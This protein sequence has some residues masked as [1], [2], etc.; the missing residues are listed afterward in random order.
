MT[1]R[2]TT[3]VTEVLAGGDRR[4]RLMHAAE[5]AKGRSATLKES[6]KFMEEQKLRCGPKGES[7]GDA[8]G[9]GKNDD[10]KAE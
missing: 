5:K 3:T 1:R 2:P 4:S 8:K 6:R 7:K 9:K 10:K